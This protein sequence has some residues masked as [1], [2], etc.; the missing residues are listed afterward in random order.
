MKYMQG[1]IDIDK[2]ALLARINLSEK[3]KEKLQKEFG[4][5]LDYV[6]ELKKAEVGE[7]SDE[8]IAM[9]KGIKNIAR[10]DKESHEAAVGGVHVKVKHILR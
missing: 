5:I 6:S 1:K 2:L 4:S 10:E 7:M 8:E 9:A 3:E